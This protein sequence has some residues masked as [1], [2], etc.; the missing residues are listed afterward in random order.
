[1]GFNKER[2]SHKFKT[3]GV[4]VQYEIAVSILKGDVVWIHG[5]FPCGKWPDISI[6]RDSLI[7]HLGQNERVEAT[8]E[9]HR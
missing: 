9:K 8:S 3:A 2:Y 1:M 7:N 4:R 6:F 5:P